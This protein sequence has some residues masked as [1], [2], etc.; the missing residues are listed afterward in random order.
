MNRR[1]KLEPDSAFIKELRRAGGDSL[2]KCYQC[3]MCSVVCDLSQNGAVFPRKEMIWAQWGLKERLMSD[4][5]VWLCHQCNDCTA[6]CPRGAK[7]GDVLAAVRSG[8]FRSFAFPSFMGRALASPAALPFLMLVPVLVLLGIIL[9]NEGIGFTNPPPTGLHPSGG[10]FANFLPHGL[11]EMLFIGGN[12]FIF[13]LAALGLVKFWKGLK[14]TAGGGQ[15]FIPSMIQTVMEILSHGKFRKCEANSSRSWAHLLVF[16]GF[17][18]AMA[19]AG[20][21]V[22]DMMV[23]GHNPPIP[24]FH[25]IKILGNLSS[26]AL[27]VGCLALM[28]RKIADREKAGADKYTDWLFLL[29]LFGVSLTGVLVQVC[30]QAGPYEFAYIIYFIHIALVFFLLWYAPYSKFAHMFY[31]TLA[32]AYVKGSEKVSEAVAPAD[33]S[34]N[35]GDSSDGAAAPKDS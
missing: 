8:V 12:V 11:L 28:F 32:L 25:P 15:G 23:L 18:G 14:S 7:P 13:A 29:V 33:G 34:A 19:T 26:A 5:H 22:F 35:R 31:R 2:K 20:L 30:R 24:L 10:Y 9:P 6:H 21:A 1:V 4:P 3:A 16:Y 27:V 17:F